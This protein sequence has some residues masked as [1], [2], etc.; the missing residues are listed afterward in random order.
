MRG[1]SDGPQNKRLVTTLCVVAAFLCFLYFYYGSENRGASAIEYGSKSLKRLGTSYLVR[2]DD[3]D[4]KQSE[5]LTKFGQ[6]DDL[7]PKSFPVSVL[8]QQQ[9]CWTLFIFLIIA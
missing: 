2:D 1:R 9:N 4:E 3:T 5:S 8:L 7:I 6:D